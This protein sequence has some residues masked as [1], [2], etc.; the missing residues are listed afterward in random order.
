MS[1]PYKALLQHTFLDA[2]VATS[3]GHW[4]DV[5]GWKDKNIH[6]SGISGDTVQVF[7]SNSPTVPS[8]STTGFQ[9][10]DDITVDQSFLFTNVPC[11][12]MKVSMTRSAGTV[13]A[14]GVGT[15]Y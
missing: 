11:L 13:T 7:G 4:H 14:W 2:V 15:N 3:N 8:D 1:H 5:S 10:G 6:V 9:I 12:W